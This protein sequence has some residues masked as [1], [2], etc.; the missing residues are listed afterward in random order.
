MLTRSFRLPL[1]TA[2]AE[3]APRPSPAPV[4]NPHRKLYSGNLSAGG[5]RQPKIAKMPG[6]HGAA[7]CPEPSRVAASPAMCWRSAA[8]VGC[9][10]L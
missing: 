9:A 3:P 1:F 5:Y 4:V 7:G 8:L 2:N 10:A 6:E